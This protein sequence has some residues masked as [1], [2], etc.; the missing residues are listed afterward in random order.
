MAKLETTYLTKGRLTIPGD[1]ES[2]RISDVMT[3]A[4]PRGLVEI[5]RG[6]EMMPIVLASGTFNV[7]QA[8]RIANG[9]LLL[10]SHLQEVDPHGH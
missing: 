8:Y 1:S 10:A 3:D 5:L 4:G 9:F 2:L 7:E 6:G